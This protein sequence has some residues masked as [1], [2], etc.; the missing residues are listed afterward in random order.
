VTGI[1]RIGLYA[2]RAC[3]DVG[4]LAQARGLDG[5]RFANLLMRRKSLHMPFEDPVSFAVNAGRPVV[6]ALSEAER[7]SIRLLVIASESG[8]DFG[9]SMGTYVAHYLGL[10]AHCRTFEIKQACYGGTAALRTAAALVAAEGGRALVICTDLA[11]PVPFSYAEPSQGAAAVALLVGP[12]PRLLTLE[13]GALE[14]HAY[15]VMDACRPTADAETGDA[16]L[17]LLSYLDCAEKAFAAYRAAVGGADFVEHF[18]RLAFH[19]P[20]GGMVKGAHRTLMRKTSATPPS[21]AAVEADFDRRVGPSLRWCAEVG[22]IYS[23]TVFLALAGALEGADLSQ[24]QR[25]G[26]FSYGSGCCSEFYSGIAGPSAAAALGEAGIAAH[27]AERR[28]LTLAEYEDLLDRQK[29]FYGVRSVTVGGGGM[30]AVWDSHFA[31]QGLL[32]LEGIDDWRRVY[33]WS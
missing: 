18:Y 29:S 5:A 19:T 25:I 9:K 11:R 33:R 23:G 10:P 17:S 14:V 12:Q 13:P 2:G 1:E 16:D 28:A 20:F 30:E 7:Q 21:A 31:G 32:V 8:V 22:N 15:E 26:L 6:A 3:L 4:V 24:P 27:L